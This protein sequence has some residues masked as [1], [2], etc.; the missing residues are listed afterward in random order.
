MSKEAAARPSLIPPYG[1]H[2]VDLRVPDAEVGRLVKETA[3]AKK[4]HLSPRSLCDLELLAVGALSP[5]DTFMGEATYRRVL[6]AMRL[7]SGLPW[8]I[9]ITLPV[10]PEDGIHLGEPLVLLD[11]TNEPLAVLDVEEVFERDANEAEIVT[12]TSD[13]SHP[14]V[15]EMEGWG[16][17]AVSG[18]LRVLQ[19]PRH[20]DF[21]ELRRTPRETRSALEAMGR[22]DVVAFQTRNPM[23]RAHE[24]LTK[25]AAERVGGSLLIHPAVGLTKPGDV[26]H[27]TRVRCYK[28][29]V[30][31]GYDPGT[32][33]LSLLPIA[34]R[35]AGP[36]EAVWHA[37]IRRNYGANHFIVGRDHA[38]PG[39]DSKGIPFYGPTDAQDL[40]RSMEDE[41][42]V[43]M[44]P[45]EE[46]V[47]VEGEE[48]YMERGEVPQGATIRSISGTQV[49]EDYLAQGR[50]IPAWFTRPSVAAILASVY[51]PRT[52]QGFCVWLTGLPCSGKSTIGEILGVM[53]LEGGRQ[54]T[55]L[56]GDVVRQEL[57]KGLG[58]TR[59]DRIANNRRIGFV[60][61]EL[62]RHGG[63]VICPVVSP[64]Q[65]GR[66][67]VRR[68]VGP[69]HFIMV[70]V[71][72]PLQVCEAR[73]VKGM[74]AQARAGKI[75]GFTGVD[76]PYEA[77]AHPDV[78]VRT[79]EMSAEACARKVLEEIARRGF[80]TLY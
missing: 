19:T 73:D 35:M 18:S 28:A 46:L 43:R 27:F 55:M 58:F 57:S 78:V 8:T 16:P 2:L 38:S 51:K 15:R 1:G 31:E 65:A 22:S 23:H 62:V 13:P 5:L 37:I 41:V 49:R 10:S 70:H 20:Y 75:T 29:M 68:M 53:L 30:D 50:P 40:L 63:S 47:Y 14:T 72:T 54:S 59:G 3:G 67:E 36:R 34:M 7:P 60:A 9:P 64:Y 45:F 6:D 80:T 77:P 11:D 71:D 21:T 12:G 66:E 33:L 25:R 44:V 39:K 32:T 74:Y 48:R 26:D 42:G 76:D 52:E 79:T 56:D 69:D 24:E 4:L 61:A 17:L